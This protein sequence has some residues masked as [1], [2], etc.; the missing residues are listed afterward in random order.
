MSIKG[1]G[2]QSIEVG[3]R[4]L[5]VL[6]SEARPMMLRDLAHRAK[7]TPAQAHAYLLSLRRL[8]LVEQDEAGRYRVGPFAL[9]LGIARM[10]GSDPLKLAMQ[11]LSQ[12][13]E[14]TGMMATILVFGT[15]GPTVVY[16]EEGAN[17][18]QVNVRA[19]TLYSM[20]GTASGRVF[21]AYLADSVARVRIKAEIAEGPSQ[22][23]VGAPASLRAVA[24]SNKM[25]RAAGYATT[26]GVPIPGINAVS[27]PVFDSAGRMQLA[28]TLI[29]PVGGMSVA[30]ESPFVAATVAF[31]A[32]LSADLGY[33]PNRLLGGEG[34]V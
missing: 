1:R 2:V 33:D 15:R 7:L 29:G 24:A 3:G 28:I 30:A 26:E 34:P 13:A 22:F 20:M 9:T 21:S 17:Q 8:E 25:V 14:E 6:G 16:V 5:V 31:C 27:A 32:K 23:M 4:I 11:R 19:G 10:W 18:I 12:L